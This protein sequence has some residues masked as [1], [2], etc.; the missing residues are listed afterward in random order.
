[1]AIIMASLLV[2]CGAFYNVQVIRASDYVLRA[3]DNR[4]RLIPISAPRGT[5]YDRDGAIIAETVS[6]YALYLERG[7]L[8]SAYTR[9]SRIAPFLEMDS[10]RVADLVERVRRQPHQP[11]LIASTLSFDQV[12]RLE[13]HRGELPWIVLDA[14]PLRRYPEGEAVAH[15]IGY[16]AEISERELA[17]SAWTG[18]RMGQ[19]IGKSGIERQFERSLGGKPG[20]RYIEVDARGRTVGPF[21]A[22]RTVQPVAGQD[23]RLTLDLDLQRF[24]HRIFPKHMRGAIVAMVPS[25]G[26]VLA[27]YS[28]PTFDPN[29]LVGGVSPR[30][31][32]QL[33]EDPARPLLNRTTHGIYPPGSTWK[34]ATALIALEK[35][36]VTPQTRLPYPCVG[37]MSFANRY[38]RC[39]R[40]QGHGSLDLAGAIA[41]SCNVYFYQLG[42]RL[43]LNQLARE[44]A[45]LGFN[46]RTGIDLPT[47]SNGTFPDGVEWYRNRFGWTPTPSEVMSL[48]IGQGPNAQTPLRMTQFFSAIAGDG[49]APAPHLMDRNGEALPLETDLNVSAPTL[50]AVRDGLH[51]VMMPGGTAYM[52]SLR[53]WKMYGKTGTSQNTQDPR[54]PH[55]WFTGFAGPVDGDPEIVVSAVVEF[56][57]SGSQAAAPLAAKIADFYLNKKYGFPTDESAQTLRER[58]TTG[59]GIEPIR[60]TTQTPARPNAAPANSAP[61]PSTPANPPPSRPEPDR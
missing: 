50:A 7:P 2:V 16:V 46:R 33:N 29:E 54:R 13:E 24:A 37:G 26:E 36:V 25:T 56:G 61:R 27:L 3:E 34:L 6:S 40:P 44:G 47:E 41:H 60:P 55:A 11:L 35:G 12:A 18:Y 28:N 51:R 15:L 5:I 58:L 4:L 10:A 52:S 38:A 8:D 21:L 9:L 43:G 57:E 20:A 1:M 31:W 49:T 48:S 53:R 17:D 22:G 23:I 59:R 45:R 30:L 14:R 32:R 39:W 42:I 19:M